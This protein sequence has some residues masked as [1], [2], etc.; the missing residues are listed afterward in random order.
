MMTILRN[1]IRSTYLQCSTV[2][3]RVHVAIRFCS[4][5]FVKYHFKSNIKL[6]YAMRANFFFVLG[7]TIISC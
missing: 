4:S 7:F 6:Q 1:L 5:S 2:H 3:V